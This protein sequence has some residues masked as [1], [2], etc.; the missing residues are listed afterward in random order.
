MSISL[1]GFSPEIAAVIQDET[2]VREFYDALYPN[3]LFRAEARVEEWPAQIGE[4]TVFTRTGLSPI[5]A[6][7]I[8]ALALISSII[9]LRNG[10]TGYAFILTGLTIAAS[11]TMLF[12]GLFPRIMVS[13]TDENL[14]PGNIP[15]AIFFASS[16]NCFFH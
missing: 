7:V 10:K 15:F 4:T 8:A 12:T 1:Q 5:P 9:F 16:N 3:L 2:L 14:I 13:S 6:T 11:V